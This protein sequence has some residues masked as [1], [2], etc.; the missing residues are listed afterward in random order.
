LLRAGVALVVVIPNLSSY[1]H[2]TF[3][4]NDPVYDGRPNIDTD[5]Y[6]YIGW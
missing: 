1:E 3:S 2:A 4:A 5:T 6:S